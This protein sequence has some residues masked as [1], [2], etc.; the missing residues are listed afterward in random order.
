MFNIQI[1]ILLPKNQV[2]RFTNQ[3]K[4]HVTFA[5]VTLN[6]VTQREIQTT[7]KY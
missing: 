6:R 7:V 5:F 2:A 4:F 1:G 3:P